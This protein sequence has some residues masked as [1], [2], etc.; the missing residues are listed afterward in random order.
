MKYTDEGIQKK[1]LPKEYRWKVKSMDLF[2][3]EKE[4]HLTPNENKLLIFLNTNEVVNKNDLAEYLYNGIV[5]KYTMRCI[6]LCKCRLTKKTGL[7]IA[8]TK[9]GYLLKNKLQVI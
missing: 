2:I 4:I 7:I 3:G 8:S 9:E 1:K 5:D 6:Y